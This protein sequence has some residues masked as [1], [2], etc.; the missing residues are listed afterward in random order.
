MTPRQQLLAG[1][2]IGAMAL[3][4][5]IGARESGRP[6][7]DPDAL[8]SVIGPIGFDLDRLDGADL[9]AACCPKPGN[10]E[11]GGGLSPGESIGDHGV[12]G[13]VLD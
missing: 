3:A 12:S 7:C 4:G 5:S 2:A 8:G 13:P 11:P 10:A 6:R 9:G 1:V